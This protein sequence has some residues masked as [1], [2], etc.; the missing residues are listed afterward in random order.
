MAYAARIRSL[1]GDDNVVTWASPKSGLRDTSAKAFTVVKRLK[2]LEWIDSRCYV[3]R[4]KKFRYLINSKGVCDCW[5]R[6][7]RVYRTRRDADRLRIGCG[8]HIT[9]AIR[10]FRST[11]LH[12]QIQTDEY[13]STILDERSHIDESRS[14]NPDRKFQIVSRLVTAIRKRLQ[15]HS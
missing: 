3:D 9:V 13:R 11:I 7:Q 15:I 4:S 6:E 2:D 1:I 5:T 14:T 10:N 8:P 12:R